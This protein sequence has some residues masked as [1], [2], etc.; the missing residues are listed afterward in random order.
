MACPRVGAPMCYAV[1]EIRD[2]LST[3]G[4]PVPEGATHV[5]YGW[6]VVM[7]GVVVMACP[8][9]LRRAYGCERL[10]NRH[11]SVFVEK[12]IVFWVVDISMSRK[13]HSTTPFSS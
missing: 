8:V 6:I 13:T 10:C 12:K 1:E 3:K 7:R 9:P 4:V 2:D 5:Q 11:Q